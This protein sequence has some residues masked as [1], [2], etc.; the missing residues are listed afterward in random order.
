MR[1]LV[2]EDE[3][4]IADFL[5]RGLRAEG[6]AVD[7]A[8]DGAE[9]ER[10][11]LNDPVDLVIL[12]VMLP[13]RDGL[14]VLGE[15]RRRRPA[16]PVILLTAREEIGDRVAGL[17]AGATDYVTKPFAFDELAAR[18]RTHLRIAHETEP[19]TLEEGDIR[20]DLLSRQVTRA[21]KRISLSQREADL[22]A[23][24]LRRPNEVIS[25]PQ[26]LERVWGPDPKP[27]SNVVDVYVGTLRRKLSV[28]G[29]PPPIDTLRSAGYRL[30]IHE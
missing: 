16:L 19:A 4:A 17:D 8:L 29:Q 28:T 9:G 7:V 14:D 6:Y 3:P 15:I 26:I 21:G 11:A 1:V 22:L 23:Y 12:D 5:Q 18:V 2:V 27:A 13:E 25:R 30:T 24:F 10:R 20:L